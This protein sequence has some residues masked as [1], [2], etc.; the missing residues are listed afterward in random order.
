VGNVVPAGALT[1]PAALGREAEARL[2]ADPTA[3]AQWLGTELG[4]L[5]RA[6]LSASTRQSLARA[7]EPSLA[8]LRDVAQTHSATLGPSAQL[9]RREFFDAMARLATEHAYAWKLTLANAEGAVSVAGREGPV[10]LANALR[11]LE[12]E[13]LLS[14]AV[15]RSLH[16]RTWREAMEIARLAGALGLTDTSVQ[17]SDSDG[18]PTTQTIGGMFLRLLLTHLLLPQRLPRGG[19]WL[20]HRYLERHAAL[21][22]FVA[23]RRE[24]PGEFFM[25]VDLQGPMPRVLSA[26]SPEDLASPHARHLRL[27]AL[28][29][30]VRQEYAQ[31]EQGTAPAGLDDVAPELARQV[32]KGMLIAW[33]LR[34]PR[35]AKREPA[36]GWLNAVVG[37]DQIVG[38]QPPTAGTLAADPAQ[39]TPARCFQLDQSS[40]GVALEFR[41]QWSPAVQIGQL[42]LLQRKDN[43]LLAMPERFV[44]VIRRFVLRPGDV[45]MAGLQQ[46]P[47]RPLPVDIRDPNDRLPARR[48]LLLRRSGASR[49][50]LLAPPGSYRQHAECAISGAEGDLVALV[51]KLLERTE[52]FDRIEMSVAERLSGA[53]PQR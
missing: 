19:V 5:N 13:A 25:S 1:D 9:E 24:A 30:R 2:L 43:D 6:P 11:A 53:L 4:R 29:A 27:T 15:Y 38:P 17:V 35:Q 16:H 12:L 44:A 49:L 28:F 51:D 47:G 21:G 18:V 32:L 34:P 31:L 37:F 10:S 50:V 3:A 7:V 8:T 42:L 52:F 46:L 22:A 41:G 14:Y 33:Y 45:L 20:A 40:N 26:E 36:T 48:G 23:T 39:P